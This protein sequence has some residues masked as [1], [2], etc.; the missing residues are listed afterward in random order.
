MH[1]WS[2]FV[3]QTSLSSSWPSNEV[4]PDNF[5]NGGPKVMVMSVLIEALKE[6]LAL[7]CEKV[8]NIIT[9]IK[10]PTV[11]KVEGIG[12]EIISNALSKENK[13]EVI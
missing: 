1:L 7:A 4:N 12:G 10:L 8:I 11:V 9:K 5:I 6:N 2:K 3:I 13:L